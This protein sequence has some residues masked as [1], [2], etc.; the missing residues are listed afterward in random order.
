M[1]PGKIASQAGH[2]F[3]GA[4]LLC[5]DCSLLA[6]YHRDFPQTPGTKVCLAARNLTELLFVEQK[7]RAAGLSIFRVI[8]SGCENFFGGRP[9]ITAL[10]IGPARQDEI[11]HITR[12]LRLL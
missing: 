2:A 6:E 9:T 7:A 4:F 8:D 12:K 10:G 3:L 5:R 1:S 11:R